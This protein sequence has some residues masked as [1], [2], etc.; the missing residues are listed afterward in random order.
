MSFAKYVNTHLI[1]IWNRKVNNESNQKEK[2]MCFP[3]RFQNFVLRVF[4]YNY[5]IIK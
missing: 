2:K 1:F 4:V 3:L 5:Y